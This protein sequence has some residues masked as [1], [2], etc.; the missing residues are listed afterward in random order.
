MLHQISTDSLPDS[1]VVFELETTGLDASQH[2]IIEIA[3]IRFKKGTTAHNT[4]QAL[5]KPKRAAVPQRIT[6][7]TGIT[8]GMIDRDGDQMNCLPDSCTS[9]WSSLSRL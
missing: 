6:E 8:Q 3:A 2:E 1:F 9:P 5:V 4:L 7:L